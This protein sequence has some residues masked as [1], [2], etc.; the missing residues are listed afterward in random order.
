MKNYKTILVDAY[1]T[2]FTDMGIDQ[3]ILSVL[4]SYVNKKIVLTNASDDQMIQFGI[5]KSP[6]EVFTLKHEPN[7]TDGGYY[8]IMLNQ[9][10]LKSEDCIYFEHNKTAVEE[11]RSLGIET[12]HFSKEDKNYRELTKF[13]EENI[14]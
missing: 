13:I 4:E 3:N 12:H 11:A 14:T 10:D 6:Y 2:L 8:E 1:N 9:Y 7:K 5:D